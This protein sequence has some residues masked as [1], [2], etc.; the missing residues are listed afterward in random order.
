[1]KFIT[2]TAVAAAV[3]GIVVTFAPAAATAAGCPSDAEVRAQITD[4]VADMRDDV[5]ARKART[6]TARALRTTL[7]TFG[8]ARA[9]NAAERRELGEQI[10]QL[11][12]QRRDSSNRVENRALGTQIRALVEQR[13]RRG[14]FTEEERAELLQAVTALR[15]AVTART[16][17]RP[18]RRDVAAA[19][20]AIVEGFSCRTA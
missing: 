6:A 8:G 10:A 15:N 16:D 2:R 3:S 13:E 17:T 7:E 18:E 20:R 4:L 5:K 11:A 12:Q 19:F 1:M 14:G 9:E